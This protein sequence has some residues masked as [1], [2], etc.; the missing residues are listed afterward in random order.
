[1]SALPD[2]N[3]VRTTIPYPNVDTNEKEQQMFILRPVLK[4]NTL[5]PKSDSSVPAGRAENTNRL[6]LNYLGRF[7]VSSPQPEVLTIDGE[8]VVA[9]MRTELSHI[10]VASHLLTDRAK[11]IFP[12]YPKLCA[13][14]GANVAVQYFGVAPRIGF[15]A[16]IA[17]FADGG[18]VSFPALLL[19]DGRIICWRTSDQ[20]PSTLVLRPTD[21]PK[22]AAEMKALIGR[23]SSTLQ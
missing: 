19:G 12:S 16:R 7:R 22:R 23:H 13:A 2:T 21:K 6:R 17:I 8:S 20:R 5:G 9:S 4:R 11:D 18:Q 15:T 3:D 14:N 1:M 10:L